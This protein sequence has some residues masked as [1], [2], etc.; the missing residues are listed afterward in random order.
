LAWYSADKTLDKADEATWTLR[1]AVTVNGTSDAPAFAVA[2]ADPEPVLE[3]QALGRSL[4]DFL[5]TDIGPD[6]R[7]Y[8][9]YARRGE[10]GR[11][12]NRVVVSDG[13]LALGAGVPRNGPS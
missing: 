2:Q 6:G 3:K 5:E 11:L 13:A 10:D 8:T 9:I 7:L 1:V 12:V 4:G